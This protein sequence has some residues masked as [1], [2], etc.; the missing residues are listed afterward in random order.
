VDA[1]YG[2]VADVPAAFGTQAF[3]VEIPLAILGPDDGALNALALLG[4]VTS[5]TD[6]VPNQGHM[7]IYH[8]YIPMVSRSY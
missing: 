3:T 5:P 8:I 2:P 7:G 6:C 1:L 4:N